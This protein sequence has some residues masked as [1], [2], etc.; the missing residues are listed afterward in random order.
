MIDT[1][2]YNLKTP[3]NSVSLSLFVMGVILFKEGYKQED[4]SKMLEHA[5]DLI[6]AINKGEACITERG[7]EPVTNVA[8]FTKQ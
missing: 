7:I 4:V 1:T 3:L 2:D 5:G 6:I 8:H